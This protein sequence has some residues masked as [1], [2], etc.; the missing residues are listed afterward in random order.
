MHTLFFTELKNKYDVLQ[1]YEDSEKNV[2]GKSWW[3]KFEDVCKETA[4]KVLG[5]KKM[6]ASHGSARN[7]GS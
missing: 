3:Q 5:Y 1:D 2:E 4:K 6:G 7:P